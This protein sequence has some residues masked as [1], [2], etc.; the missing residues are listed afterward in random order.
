MDAGIPADLGFV[1]Q[2][3]RKRAGDAFSPYPFTGFGS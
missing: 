1:V 2:S 3:I